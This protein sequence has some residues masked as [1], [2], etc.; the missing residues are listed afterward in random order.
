MKL[1]VSGLNIVHQDVVPAT[2]LYLV[3]SG[4]TLANPAKE[5]F[6]RSIKCFV[7][8]PKSHLLSQV[9]NRIHRPEIPKSV[10]SPK[11]QQLM[12]DLRRCETSN[13]EPDCGPF[14]APHPLT[15]FVFGVGQGGLRLVLDL[16]NTLLDD[17]ACLMGSDE[18]VI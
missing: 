7:K 1:G 12:D 18:R 9:V 3:Q 10:T 5:E 13:S 14:P 15:V 2:D 8:A 16:Q 4:T 6:I 11:A 17:T